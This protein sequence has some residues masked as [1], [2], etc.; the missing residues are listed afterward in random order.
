VVASFGMDTAQSVYP[1][2]LI[3]KQGVGE[4]VARVAEV[5]VVEVTQTEAAGIKRTEEVGLFRG[6][7]G[8]G[9]PPC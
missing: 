3:A 7:E 9:C 8:K 2:L 1:P 5:A 4:R 6:G